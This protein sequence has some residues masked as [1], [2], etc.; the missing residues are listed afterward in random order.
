MPETAEQYRN[1]MNSHL[2]GSDPLTLMA[3]A[4]KKL[5]SLVKGVSTAKMRRGA[6]SGWSRSQR[7]RAG[8]RPS[9]ASVR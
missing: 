9:P 5:E 8:S 1:R 3:A 2:E 7:S 6:G 4:P